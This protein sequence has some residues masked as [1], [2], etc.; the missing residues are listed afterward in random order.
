MAKKI[1]NVVAENATD[2]KVINTAPVETGAPASAPE[3]V[4]EK[5]IGENL[6]STEEIERLLTKGTLEELRANVELIAQVQTEWLLDN[7][8]ASV[9][10]W[11]EHAD[12]LCS[13]Y[14]RLKRDECF[15]ACLATADPMVTA[16]TVMVYQGIKLKENKG[17]SEG[18]GVKRVVIELDRDIDLLKLHEHAKSKTGTGIGHDKQWLHKVQKLNYLLAIKV[19]Q[20][21]GD[22]KWAPENIEKISAS[23]TMSDIAKSFNMGKNPVS[24]TQML[25]TLTTI[26]QSMIGEGYKPKSHDVNWLSEAYSRKDRRARAVQLPNH[27]TFALMLRDVC[28]NCI[29]DAGYEANSRA[30]KK[31]K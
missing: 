12:K 4:E 21:I 1:T 15:N 26:V 20:A 23:F 9:V 11:D 24:N 22:K 16:C 14:N 29:T 2:E 5:N 19:G 18:E 30:C 17:N 10:K 31:E 7:D 25:K 28:N 3:E 8:V 27:K 6:P 13:R